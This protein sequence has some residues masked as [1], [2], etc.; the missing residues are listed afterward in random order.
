[1]RWTTY[2][3]I[4]LAVLCLYSM[5]GA[6]SL[7]GRITDSTGSPIISASVMV[8]ADSTFI[9]GSFT[10]K[11]GSFSLTI[12]S[13]PDSLRL[14]AKSI[15]YSSRTHSISPPVDFNSNFSIVLSEKSIDFGTVKVVSSQT[16]YDSRSTLTRNEIARASRYSIVPTNPVSAIVQPQVIR[17]G[18]QHSSKIRILGTSPDY[19]LNNISIGQDPNHYGI[20][21]IIPGLVID[22]M[23]LYTSGT[24]ARYSKS[25]VLEITTPKRFEEHT[26]GSVN[27]SFIEATGSV[28]YGT[29]KTFVLGSVRKSVLDKLIEKLDIKSNR[30]TIP[31]TNFQDIFLTAGHMLSPSLYIVSDQFHSRDYLSYTTDPTRNNPEGVATFQHSRDN[32]FSLGLVGYSPATTFSA[33]VSGNIKS[34]DYIAHSG[35]D[36]STGGI[37]ADMEAY[38]RRYLGSADIRSS[39]KEV[40]LSAGVIGEYISRRMISL[41]QDNWNFLPPDA[42]SDNPHLFQTALNNEYGSYYNWDSETNI[43]GFFSVIKPFNKI[44]SESGMRVDH[45]GNLGR[46][47]SFTFRQSVRYEIADGN[48][49]ELFAGTYTENPAGRILEA[50][51]VLIHA[52]LQ[53]LKPIESALFSVSCKN[54]SVKLS[55]YTR[56]V[57]SLP[58]MIPDYGKVNKNM[59]VDYGFITIQSSG[60]RRFYGSS[61]S[62]ESDSLFDDRFDLYGF[63]GYNKAI[64]TIAD[65]SVP[66]ELNSP[67]VVYLAGDYRV[68]DGIDIGMDFTYRSGYAY[69]PAYTSDILQSRDLYSQEFY[70]DV[71]RLENSD[72]F[73]AFLTLNIRGTYTFGK[74]EIFGSI[75]NLTNHNNPIINTHDGFVYDAGLLPSV[76]IIHT[77]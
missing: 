14:I 2:I 25:S 35:V 37:Q 10:D 77:F 46:K 12:N 31:P 48:E 71:L 64:K 74:T 8:Y 61:I 7:S 23:K 47:T 53:E 19:Y 17:A 5:T 45:F 69:T 54:R 32:Y 72:R 33:K 59:T 40:T 42:T 21:T 6:V 18:S 55:L 58:I 50:Y 28:S 20:F 34:E 24:P 11:N 56:N 26:G 39:Y 27:L 52:N 16:Q 66:Y 51:Q 3:K 38:Q 15:G 44:K 68:N 4:T 9:T 65:V 49:V 73:P 70:E 60:K 67:H 13:T 76:G 63:Y 57:W 36:G 43:S 29:D 62:V 30:R 22:R 1:M 41:K 75:A